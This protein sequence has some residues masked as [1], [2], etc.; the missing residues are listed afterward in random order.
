MKST[1]CIICLLLL[2]AS[3]TKTEGQTPLKFRDTTIQGPQTFAIVVGVSEYKYV[4]PLTYADKDAILFSDYLK[5]PGGGSVNGDNI[6]MLLNEEA[7]NSNFWTKGFQWLKAK[8]LQKGDKLFIYLAG[9]GDAIDQD[10]FFFLGYDCN[11]EGDKN[12]YLVAGTIQLFN[13]KKKISNET[14]KGVEVFFIMDAC[15][16]NELPGGV[17]GQS[18]LNTAISEKKVGE[19]IM[20]ATGA[21]QE[22][23]EDKSIGNGHGLFTYYLVDGLSG[24][25][26]TDGTPDFK[27]TFSEIQ[28]YVDKN[29]PSVA[30]ERFKRSQDPYFC[31]NE[32]TEKVISNVDPTYLQKW[33]QTKRAQNGGGNSFNGMIKSGSRNYAD[34]LLVE[35]YNQFNRAIKNNNIVGNKSA[36]EY[37]QQL[38]NKYPGNPYTLDAKSSL[39]VK[40]IDFAQAKVNRYLSCSD[41]LSAKQ[42]QENTD[43]ATRL[44][45]AI[46]YVR[47]DDADFANSLRG[48]LFL[49]KASGNNV[50]SAVSFQNAYSALSID[51]NGAYIQNKLALLHLENNNKDSA[52]FYADKA[53]RT[54][55]NWRCALT[56]LALVQNAANKTPENKNVKK[57]SPFRKVSFGG[58]IGGGLNQSNPTYSGNANSS[59]DDVRSNT[60][61]AF[62]LG[63][64]VQVNIGNNIFIR[65]SVTAS[66]G[67]TDIDFIRKPLTGGQ[68]IVETIGLKGTSANI[69]LPLLVRLSSKK[70]APYIMLGPSFSYLVSQD[71]RSVELLPIKKSLFSGN[72]GIGVDFGLGNSGLSLSPELKYT[73]GF[74]DTK[75]PAATTSYNLAL[76]SLKKNTFSFNLYLRKK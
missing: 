54:A 64:I 23:L 27:V 29:V 32:N 7:S 30:K 55:P 21:G 36:E 41:D 57:N 3:F 5:S 14:A 18:F 39:T 16:S 19:I 34:T 74:S 17:S 1:H 48:R 35:T 75:D 58:T 62:D 11:P 15:R 44:E 67:S 50:S 28:K 46:N 20:L 26:D 43:A 69:E 37:Y 49:L 63:I 71:S 72:G 66:F 2:I 8:K 6:F 73:A 31:C 13:L 24:V 59:Y 9:H 68:E 4:K 42:K 12:N 51:P 65:P 40:Y 33:L 52:L 22:S 53:A 38:N 25:A 10:Q 56:T 70:I 45:K 60:A 47:E 61:P 76:S